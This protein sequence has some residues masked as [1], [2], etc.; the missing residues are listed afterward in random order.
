MIDKE[1]SDKTLR[2][3]LSAFCEITLYT[4]HALSCYYNKEKENNLISFFS[5]YITHFILLYMFTLCTKN[6]LFIHRNVNTTASQ[7]TQ[8]WA[9]M[10]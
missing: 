5:I 9:L 3:L 4:T 8:G 10:Y 7:S 6:N 1:L 2:S